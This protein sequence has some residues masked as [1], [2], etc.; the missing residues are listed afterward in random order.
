MALRSEAQIGALVMVG[1]CAP[2]LAA[3]A[4]YEVRHRHLH[5]G[6]TGVLRVADDA[7]SFQEAGK[8][9]DHS[10]EWRFAEIQQLTLSDRTLRVLT[11]EDDA[12]K[13]GRDRR[14]VFDQLPEGM[15][16]QLFPLFSRRFDQRFV[17][18]LAESAGAA[19]WRVAAR[20]LRNTGGSQGEI[21]VSA[22]RVVYRTAAPEQSRTWRITDID[23]VS[24][25]SPFD[26]TITTFEAAG[27]DFRFQ[28]KRALTEGEYNTLWRAVNQ[29]KGLRILGPLPGEKSND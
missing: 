3:D 25:G 19:E 17:A 20:L 21:A 5:G 23:N 4:P 10:R 12:V 11:Y 16:A 29:S 26:L 28:L 22:D 9:K 14:F 15:A 13:F 8:H 6:T 2:L 27:R 1:L 18:A 7:I 24:S